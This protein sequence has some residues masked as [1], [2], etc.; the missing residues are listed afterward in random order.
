MQMALDDEESCAR[1]VRKADP[2]LPDNLVEDELARERYLETGKAI[3][4]NFQFLRMVCRAAAKATP[5]QKQECQEKVR[6]WLYDRK[7]R[8]DVVM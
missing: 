5:E 1:W 4:T 3:Y 2:W 8:T 7:L 6:W